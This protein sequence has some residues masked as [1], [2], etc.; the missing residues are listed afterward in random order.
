MEKTT[1]VSKFSF[2]GTT[3]PT[4]PNA[5]DNRQASDGQVKFYLDLCTQKKV[6]PD[7]KYV[8]WS[9][10]EMRDA[11]EVLKAYYPAS[12]R[13]IE[14]IH[15]KVA[16]LHDA[17]V[18]IT[19]DFD[20]L[21]GGLNGTASQIINHLIEL[22]KKYVRVLPTDAQLNLMV[23]MYPCESIDFESYGIM[24]VNEE[25]IRLTPDAFAEE[26]TKN[27]S[28]DEASAFI[29]KFRA[30]FNEWRSTR[31]RPKQLAYIK[32]LM[33]RNG[34]PIDEIELLM[35]SGDT[36]S[37]FIDQLV[38]ES[39]TR[40]AQVEGEKTFD[41]P[42]SIF[43]ITIAQDKA[44]DNLRSAMFKIVAITSHEPDNMETLL[45]D[46]KLISEYLFFCLEQNLIS[47]EEIM[48]CMDKSDALERIF[49]EAFDA[50]YNPTTIAQ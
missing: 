8:V 6:E 41:L 25:K 2:S 28:K 32:T 19:I 43:S 11:I 27:M 12:D 31:V 15:T 18:D 48:S 49:K 4:T 13:Q 21:S 23:Q 7:A 39:K 30:D 1:T 22:E 33:E 16:N 50:K 45:G 20:N 34:S 29:D 46:D 36:A 14:L 10:S 47:V 38:K 35:M 37:Q 17:G 24:R 5:G 42:E 3:S 40:P 9:F 26:I 44:E